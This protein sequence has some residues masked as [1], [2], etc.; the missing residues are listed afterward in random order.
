MSDIKSYYSSHRKSH[1]STLHTCVRRGAHTLAHIHTH[2]HTHSGS[3]RERERDRERDRDRQT[4]VPNVLDSKPIRISLQ[5]EENTLHV[6][7]V[8]S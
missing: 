3:Q 1:M 5:G 6:L 4:E 2:T 7:V 8:P